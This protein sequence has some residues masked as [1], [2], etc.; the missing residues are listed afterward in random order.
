MRKKVALICTTYNC[1]DELD[2]ALKTFTSP[3]DLELLD[4][5]VIVDGGSTDGTWRLLERYAETVSKLKVYQVP[6]ANI[7]RGRNEAI[8]RSDAD[9]IV[10]FDSGT[11]Y[12]DNWLELMLKPFEDDSIS[13]VGSLTVCCGETLFETCLASFGQGSGKD[14]TWCSHR[15]IAY[16]RTVWEQIGGYPEHVE[17]GEDSWFNAQW[18]KLGVRYVHVPE[19]RVYWRT[20]GSW[21]AVFK[22]S[23]RNSKGHVALGMHAGTI[24]MFLI[25]A[26]YLLC[27]A[28]VILG[29]YNRLMWYVAIGFYAVYVTKRMMGKGRWRKFMNPVRLLVGV[30]ALTAFDL[31]VAVGTIEGSMLLFKHKS[32]KKKE[33]DC[34]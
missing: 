4:E 1:K 32:P 9:I 16:L 22:M 31:G 20:R 3:S 8:G 14:S 25:T 17:A 5:I 7:S 21:R 23:R 24:T 33:C 29:A 27:G 18:K 34:E 10:S 30:Y 26:V 12:S 11:R 19:A 2:N 15:G 6:G 13:V 28:C